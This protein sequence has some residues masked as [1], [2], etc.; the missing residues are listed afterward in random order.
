MET[1]EVKYNG[2][3]TINVVMKD[4]ATQLDEV[5]VN[6]GYQKIDPRKSTSAITTIKAADIMNPAYHSID[7]MLE[8]HVP[9]MIFM[10]NSGQLG[11]TPRLRIRGTSTIIG[12]Q[13]PLWVVDGV[14]QYDPVNVDPSKSMISIS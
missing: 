2:Q 4:A 1:Q 5:V 8:G 13:E 14:I 11:A 10:Q 12:N 3:D 9:G 6:T 7:Q